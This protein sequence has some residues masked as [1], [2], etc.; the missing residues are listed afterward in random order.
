MLL[1]IAFVEFLLIPAIAVAVLIGG[2]KA[3]KSPTVSRSSLRADDDGP[4]DGYDD[5]DD[6]GGEP[7]TPLPPGFPPGVFFALTGRD[8]ALRR[9]CRA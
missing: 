9:T 3:A 8:R 6:D 7:V 2:S 4:N 1:M 5:T